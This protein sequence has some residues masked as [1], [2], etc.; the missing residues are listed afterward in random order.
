M[1]RKLKVFHGFRNYGTQSG[2]MARELRRKGIHAVSVTEHDAFKRITDIT[3]RSNGKNIPER[4]FNYVINY[5]Y[6][7]SCFFRYNTFHFY[8][9][10]TLTF[11]EWELPLYRLFKKKVIFNYLG[12]EVQLYKESIEKYKYTNMD[13]ISPEERD[14]NRDLEIKRRLA[15][16]AKYGDLLIVCSP[17]YSEF[18]P[19]SFVLPLGIDISE[20]TYTP[21]QEKNELVIMHAPTHR[22]YKGTEY[23]IAAIDRLIDEGYPIRKMLVENV[24]HAELKQKYIECDL[25]ID[26]I[27]AGWYGT[28]SIE[29]MALGR[30]VICA[31]RKEYFQYIDYGN[32]IPILHADPDNIYEVVKQAIGDKIA[33]KQIGMKSREFVEKHHDISNTADKLIEYYNRL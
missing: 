17:N 20:Y 3:L 23:I 15:Y 21:V 6:K 32:E 33:L 24:T 18:V 14:P 4:L 27:M 22:G 10:A 13:Y 31:I 29:A 2:L 25:F 26:Q 5:I 30:P 7:L 9:G 1:N 12:S 19:D 28:A 8:Y 16:E 11:K